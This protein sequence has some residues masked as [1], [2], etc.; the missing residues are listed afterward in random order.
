MFELILGKLRAKLFFVPIL[1]AVYLLLPTLIGAKQH[2]KELA[3]QQLEEPWY[4]AVLPENELNWGLDLLGGLYLELAV[5]LEDAMISQVGFVAGDINRFV[6]TDEL[7][8]I[9]A[10]TLVSHNIR[11]FLDDEKL[12]DFRSGI[13]SV[14]APDMYQVRKTGP[15]MFF[16]VNGNVQAARK[17][18]LEA[19]K[20]EDKLQF[21]VVITPDGKH[22]AVS[23][24]K[25]EDQ[26]LLLGKIS[27]IESPLFNA[28]PVTYP[29]VVYI[30]LSDA[31]LAQL[32]KNIF[33]LAANSVRNRIDRFGV[34]EASVSNQGNDRLVVELPGVDDT[35]QVIN[36][37][38]TTGKLEFR[39]VNQTMNTQQLQVLVDQKVSELKLDSKKLY[40]F[41]ETKKINEALKADI[42]QGHEVL[43]SKRRDFKTQ[44][45]MGTTPFLVETKTEVTGD[46]V[47][48]ASV[49]VEGGRPF[50]SVSFTKT[51]AKKFGD[52]TS[53]NINRQLAI[54]LDGEV[55]SAPNIQ[56]AITGG[57]AQ[58]TLG[59][60]SFYDLQRE[61]NEL[62]FVLKE[63]ALPA[64]LSVATKNFIGPSLGDAS[65]KAGMTSLLIAAG[66]ILLFMVM[67]YKVGGVVANV[68]LII[69][70]LLIF[71]MLCLF[72]ASLTLPG[73]AGIVLTLGMAVDA[74]VIIFER[75]REEQY[76]GHDV[77]TVVRSGYDHAKSAI[78]D[79]NITTF[80]AGFMLFTFGTGPIRGFATTL[81]IG[82]LTTL[83]TAFVFTRFIYEWMVNSVRIKKLRI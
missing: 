10:T 33:E 68:A 20:S 32:E 2:K 14:L 45:L 24:V 81:M 19:L 41:E 66:A 61:A 44:E 82:I 22:I 57:R 52:V 54:V 48:A 43:F 62:V 58:I 28:T 63:G 39:L 67:Y 55:T 50:V 29:G 36:L 78:V 75:M 9:E 16:A 15:E 80:I 6:L 49:Q 73:I 60:G 47:E 59:Y 38:Q 76:L 64:R 79:G 7:K 17:Q 65:I 8:D 46:M 12:P 40:L 74:N 77:A 31:Y 35:D 25:E 30:E 70:V 83:F 3:A 23:Y 4:Y 42:P 1:I 51:G 21:D 34:A 5:D 18:V 11:V 71:A 26:Q 27:N 53:Q 13:Q 72:Q 69:N 37:L 56:S